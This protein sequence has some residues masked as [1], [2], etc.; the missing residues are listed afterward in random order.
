LNIAILGVILIGILFTLKS[1]DQGLRELDK[2]E[3]PFALLYSLADRIFQ[4][5]W[6]K[7]YLA[8]KDQLNETMKALYVTRRTEGIWR[9]YWCNKISTVIVILFV[10]NLFSLFYF[11]QESGTSK[12]LKEHFLDRPEFGQGSE[13]VELLVAL[14]ATDEGN[15]LEAENG[16]SNDIELADSAE[17]NDLQDTQE[18]EKEVSIHKIEVL[19]EEEK[20]NEEEQMRVFKEAT[21]FLDNDILGENPSADQITTDLNFCSNIPGTSIKVEWKPEDYK[22]IH[23]D[24]KIQNEGIPSDGILTTVTAILSYEQREVEYQKPLLIKPRKYTEE[25]IILQQLKKEIVNSSERSA[26]DDHLELPETM[27]KYQ[28]H[29]EEPRANTGVLFL[30]LGIMAAVVVWMYQDKELTKRMSKRKNQLLLDYP[31]I[32]DKFTLLVNAGMTAQQAW[33]KITEDYISKKSNLQSYQRYAYE[34]M[35]V[36]VHELK[37]GIPEGEVYELFGRRIGLLPYLKFSSL[38]AQNLRKG[39]KGLSELLNREAMEAFEERK[40]SAKRL[41]EEAGTKL[42]GPMAMMLLIVLIIIIIPAFMSFQMI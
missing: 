22:L 2:K 19:I 33:N 8:K 14:E 4:I 12:L 42:L 31:E 39:S 15:D 29:W 41:G 38:I 13:E 37:L 30:V 6:I 27:D 16:K 20:L 24:G 7:R 23:L 10:C 21:K 28:L 35:L 26:K 18:H 11:L 36:S 5:P 1:K 3:H 17:T 9:I 40:E 34:E 32:I 25:E